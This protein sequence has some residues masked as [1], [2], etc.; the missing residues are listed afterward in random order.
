V[1]AEYRLTLT[2]HVEE[3]PENRRFKQTPQ[4]KREG[5][6]SPR[7]GEGQMAK[8]LLKRKNTQQQG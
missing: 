8:N 2:A 3:E 4:K 7:E 6:G 5:G 1:S